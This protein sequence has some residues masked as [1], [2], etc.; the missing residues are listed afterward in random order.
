MFKTT[1]TK[2]Q[3]KR[4]CAFWGGWALE[5]IN[6]TNEQV[7][8]A[9]IIY[10]KKEREPSG[11]LF[12]K[13]QRKHKQRKTNQETTRAKQT[14]KLE[15]VPNKVRNKEQH[16]FWEWLPPQGGPGPASVEKCVP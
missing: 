6:K 10:H 14:T 4:L 3:H 1:K 8:K 7:R 15:G 12:S 16:N 5:L 2:Q 9:Q 13:T 11:G